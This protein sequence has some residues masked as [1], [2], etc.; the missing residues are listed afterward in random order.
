MKSN[1]RSVS[2]ENVQV[3]FRASMSIS[4]DAS[5]V[6]RVLPVVGTNSTAVG[7]PST[8]AATARHTATS[9]P[10]QTPS[11]SGS[12]NPGTPVVTPQLSVPRSCTSASVCADA[13]AAERPTT[14]NAP[15]HTDVFM[16][17]L[18]LVDRPLPNGSA[19]PMRQRP[20]VF[21]IFA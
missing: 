13:P 21:L 3:V 10:C 7:S 11:A 17:N 9:K 4:P 16:S 15:S 6:K 18:F 1:F 20:D 14:A 5:D 2:R 19:A 12:A 8:A